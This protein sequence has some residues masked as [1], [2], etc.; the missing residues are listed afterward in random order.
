MSSVKDISEKIVCKNCIL[1]SK[2]P[3]ITINEGGY[4]TYCTYDEDPLENTKIDSNSQSQQSLV[5]K[6]EELFSQIR[7]E[8]NTYDVLVMF[9]GGKDSTYLLDL[10]KNKYKLRPLAFSVVHP[11]VNDASVKNMDD[12]AAKLNVD[13]IK[14]YPDLNMYKKYMKYGLIKGTEYGM[15][16]F[17]GCSLCGYI[18]NCPP[19]KT[20][21]MM[22]I[23]VILSGDTKSQGLMSFVD[24]EEKK[25]FLLENGKRPYGK[26]HHIFDDVC[27]E[28]YRG[29]LYDIS[30]ED[31]KKYRY[32]TTINP[33][34][35]IDYDFRENFGKFDDKG[36][37]GNAF[38][39][40]LTNCDA[41]YLF[42][43][44]SLKRYDCVTYIK[45]LAQMMGTKDHTLMQLE[46]GGNLDD[47]KANLLRREFIMELL[48]EYKKLL[49]YI[50]DNKI[51]GEKLSPEELANIHEMINIA[52]KIFNKQTINELINKIL[53]IHKLAD[54]YE[55][56]LAN[57]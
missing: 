40:L 42:D 26:T 24:G 34:S 18:I 14:Y 53:K 7:E 41:V 36:L 25:R 47:N 22:N 8:T 45:Q 3:D 48:E 56:D 19:L 33:L 4:C 1:H 49:F 52:P 27:G 28:E 13:L 30:I 32:P 23:P 12:V 44:L 46:V 54:Y 15:N 11:Q 16:E 50:V 38:K 6:M 29:S 37:E 5:Q 9:S 2:V 17:I 31:I 39:S 57:Y 10:V 51:S 35:I 43:Y 21:M 20:A 55:I